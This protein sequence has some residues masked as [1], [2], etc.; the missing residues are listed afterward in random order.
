M[1]AT[2]VLPLVQVPPV[3]ALVSTVVDPAHTAVVPVIGPGVA[4]TVSVDVAVPHAPAAYEIVAVPVEMVDTKPLEGFT[5]ATAL[6]LEVH[7]PPSKTLPKLITRPAQ[8]VV[9]PVMADTV[10]R[11]VTG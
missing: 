11:T 8:A 7:V 1:V 6:L 9:G 5:V 10:L 2:D 3:T 4:A